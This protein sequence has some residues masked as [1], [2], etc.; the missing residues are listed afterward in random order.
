MFHHSFHCQ[1]E[2]KWSGTKIKKNKTKTKKWKKK[3]NRTIT[4]GIKCDR[5]RATGNGQWAFGIKHQVILHLYTLFRLLLYA[6]WLSVTHALC[7]FIV[8]IWRFK[9]LELKTKQNKAK[10]F[11]PNSWSVMLNHFFRPF[12]LVPWNKQHN[13]KEFKRKQIKY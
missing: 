10:P 3:T 11:T 1:T 9:F 4:I 2:W 8:K 7:L 6:W 13:N 12:F 5:Q